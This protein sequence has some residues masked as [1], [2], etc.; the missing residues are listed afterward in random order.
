[1]NKKKQIVLKIIS[2][3]FVFSFILSSSLFIFPLQTE[4]A[5]NKD[6]NWDNPN[7]NSNPY[8]IDTKNLVNSQ[9]LMQ[10]VGC[11]GVVD[12]VSKITT[13][14]LK[15]QASRLLDKLASKEGEVGAAVQ[16][17]EDIKKSIVAAS[18]SVVYVELATAAVSAIDCKRIQTSESP[19]LL[20]Q[21]EKIA[22]ND[23]EKTK[24]EQCFDGIAYNLAK[25]QLTSMTRQTVN[26]VNTGLNGNPMYVQN[27]KSL[28]NSIE[29]GVLNEGIN[30][31]ASGAFPYGRDFSQSLIRSYNT[32]GTKYGAANFLDSLTS[33]LGAFIS[34]G[35]SYINNSS[36]AQKTALQRSQ[37]ATNRFS[38]DFSVG[39][40]DGYLALTQRESNNPLGFGMLA[41][42]RLADKT[43]QQAN[44]T[45][46]E[47]AQNNG[48]LSQKTC[49]KW[50]LYDEKGNPKT[51]GATVTDT[52]II[53]EY[54]Y[55]ISKSSDYDKCVDW[56]VIT[57]GSIIKDKLTTYINS[58]ERQ[59]ELADSINKSLNSLF[60]NLIEKFRNN[61]L[62]GISQDTYS[63]VGKDKDN[64]G[65]GGY[66]SNLGYDGNFDF[67]TS[68]GYK[69]DQFDLTRDLGNTF[70][71]E[72]T[73]S[74]GSWNA[75]TN[76][77]E[78]HLGL[79]PFSC[80]LTNKETGEEEA[81]YCQ[82]GA[83]YTVSTSGS[84]KLFLN[85]YSGWAVG[86]RAFWDG[87]SWQ[88]WKKGIA[89][90]TAKRGV[91]Q[92]QK[93]YVVAAR[94]ILKII[95]NIIPKIGELDYCI[96]GPNLSFEINSSDASTALSDYLGTLVGTTTPKAFLK[97]ART[98]YTIAGEDDPEYKAYA[99]IFN[100]T[101]SSIWSKI[102]QT[103]MWINA[104]NLGKG[105]TYKTKGSQ[106]AREDD[107][108]D[109]IGTTHQNISDFE[110][111]YN[112]KISIG[113]Y[114][115]IT[116]EFIEKEKSAELLENPEYV[117]MAQDGINITKNIIQQVED[118]NTSIKDYRD[119]IIEA[120][121][122][123]AKLNKILSEVSEIIEVAQARRNKDL[124][125]KLEQESKDSGGPVLTEA[126]YKAKYNICLSEENIPYFDPNDIMNDSGGDESLRCS[127]G[128]DN[129]LDGL[130][131]K[132]DPDCQ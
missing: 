119:E 89:S 87:K 73:K 88:N 46:Q 61:G 67:M 95:P 41:S 79:A 121:S 12:K 132:L 43:A 102:T 65:I 21:L 69:N 104:L 98:T 2:V 77:P 58:P 83:Y 117:P 26:W 6:L 72:S 34:D 50:Q 96:P 128:I 33:D 27:V 55:S 101:G 52:D 122:N 9:T 82:S 127:D 44:E 130:V 5:A 91:I 23:E 42:Q 103:S 29:K 94:E 110:N 86:D 37:E 75:K 49:K 22:A 109:F 97:R 31:F 17:C 48:F 66:G 131:D 51:I 111:E 4:A 129:D 60:T 99:N 53:D 78:L 84:T 120:E 56:N 36:G 74:L 62:F 16:K 38:N 13:D 57:P 107:I 11:T 54:E 105:D 92:M 25:N 14:F 114:G 126:Q 90:P 59:L 40:W 81:V 70:N 100:L 32:G 20:A 85:G 68:G 15:K 116:H 108:L 64:L 113:Y 71:H 10:V 115:I 80:V 3:F 39:G 118:L 35:D 106:N 24:R 1:M 63:Y 123:T 125:L 30:R 93:D 112:N 7:D 8:K 76:T 47:A 18:A 45:K 28:T 19:K 124:I